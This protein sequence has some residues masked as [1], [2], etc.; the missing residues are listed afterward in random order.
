MGLHRDKYK[1]YFPVTFVYVCPAE[2]LGGSQTEISHYTKSK[3]F[4]KE[5][6]IWQTAKISNF[7][8]L[9]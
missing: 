4:L 5:E 2:T 6:V 9:L 1:I 8:L 7:K 3:F